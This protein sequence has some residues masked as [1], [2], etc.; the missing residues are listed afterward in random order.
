[1]EKDLKVIEEYFPNLVQ[2]KKIIMGHSNGGV[3]AINFVNHFANTY[4]SRFD[5]L[6]TIDP[7]PKMGSFVVNKV[8]SKNSRT[9]T[10]DKKENIGK[11]INLYQSSNQAIMA[12]VMAIKGSTIDGVDKETRIENTNHVEI[13]FDRYVFETI[14]KEVSAQLTR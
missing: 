2:P 11:S 13:L 9:L 14:T 8:F 3:N 5:L 12:G 10:I 7:V 1:M 6:I 4:N